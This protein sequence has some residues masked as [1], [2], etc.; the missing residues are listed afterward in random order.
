MRFRWL[1]SLTKLKF[2][3][4]WLKCCLSV[5]GIVCA[6]CTR[7]CYSSVLALNPWMYSRGKLAPF[8]M[9]LSFPV[10]RTDTCASRCNA[11]CSGALFAHL[12]CAATW[13]TWSDESKTNSGAECCR[14]VL[15]FLGLRFPLQK[16]KFKTRVFKVNVIFC[17][18][19]RHHIFPVEVQKKSPFPYPSD[20][21]LRTVLLF[22]AL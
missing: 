22:T 21:T 17:W 8:E 19:W 7:H 6:T 13:R 1:N 15:G 9:P 11:L 2:L 14:G 12:L 10:E 20:L 5:G 3:K 18:H 4:F 16:D